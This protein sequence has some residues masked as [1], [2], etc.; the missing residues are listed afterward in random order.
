MFKFEET[1][2]FR[3][4]ENPRPEVHEGKDRKGFTE[5]ATPELTEVG[6]ENIDPD[7]ELA[8]EFK[9]KKRGNKRQEF[10]EN[11][12]TSDDIEYPEDV[13]HNP[14]EELDAHIDAGEEENFESGPDQIKGPRPN[15]PPEIEEIDDA[16]KYMPLSEWNKLSKEERK[17]I[18]EIRKNPREVVA[19]VYMTPPKRFVRKKKMENKKVA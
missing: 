6:K 10:R 19:E 9:I 15:L 5:K 8:K 3:N 17:K 12:I 13:Y 7:G 16:T 14:T 18:A 11:N 2:P 1:N 4:L